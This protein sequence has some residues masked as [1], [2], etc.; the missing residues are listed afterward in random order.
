VLESLCLIKI[1]L[2]QKLFS[3]GGEF[4]LWEKGSQ[5]FVN[6]KIVELESLCLIKIPLLQKLFSY[7]GE[8]FNYG[9][10]GEF[11]VFDQIYS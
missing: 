1:P 2:L 5:P 10:K 3:Y 9:K 7:G 11:L 4:R 6:L 8:F